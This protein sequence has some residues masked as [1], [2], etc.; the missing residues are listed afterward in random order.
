MGWSEHLKGLGYDPDVPMAAKVSE[1]YGWYTA[2]NDWY[3]STEYAPTA[4]RTYVVER[5]TIKPARMVAQEWASLLL[6][7][8]TQVS[9]TEEDANEWLQAW[10][11]QAHF[12]SSG[13]NLVER[14]F[15]LGTGAW[16]LRVAGIDPAAAYSPGARIIAQRF[17]ARQ[18]VPLTYDED[19]CTE[20]AFVSQTTVRGRTYD[21]VQMHLL[22][23]GGY[24]I[25]TALFDGHGGRVSL[26]GIA[27]LF[28]TRSA[29][30]LFALVRPAL[31][32]TH[33]D[34]GPFGV[35]VFDDAIGA[36]K[37]TDAALDNTYRD[38][39]LG[40]KMLFLDE[41]MLETDSS[42]NVVI[43]RERD[44]QLFRKT[45][46]DGGASRLIEEYNPTLRVDDNRTALST[47]L[48][49]LGLRC[50]MGADYFDFSEAAGLKTATEVIAEQGDLFRNIRKHEN[51][52]A[53]SIDAILTAV[54][55]LARTV[56]GAALPED[57]G[58]VEVLFDDS[59]IED[60]GALRRRDLEDV[61][62]GLMQPWEY[63]MKWY[64][65]DEAT[66]RRMVEGEP[67]PPEE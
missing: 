19:T 1:W 34:Y 20:C 7:E 49:L 17:D 38:I 63:R 64:G 36:V 65:E 26:P 3:S 13:Q 45:E 30:P 22:G 6:N 15:A 28:K 4:R 46:M 52:L 18:I 8:R 59:V 25:Q 57:P 44:Q 10:L 62:A 39:W 14:A 67:L 24:E 51:A 31:E 35:S 42:G 32:N 54:M 27:P 47:G 55:S 66:A 58:P 33:W 61:A 53:V 23:D 11:T 48:A 12:F 21:Q 2:S 41:R 40:Q 9:V 29:A 37:L 5:E 16:A 50:G 43:P 60:T 56:A